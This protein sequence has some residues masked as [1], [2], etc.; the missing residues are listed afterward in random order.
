MN[1]GPVP[2]PGGSRIEEHLNAASAAIGLPVLAALAPWLVG[3][4][5]DSPALPGALLFLAAAVFLY[6]ASTIYHLLPEGSGK[7]MARLFDHAGI[8]LLIAGTYA[9]FCLGPLRPHHG[10]ALFLLQWTLAAAGIGFKILLGFR[11]KRISNLIYLGMGWVG[12]FWLPAFLQEVGISGF[13]WILAGGLFYTA[14]L[15]FYIARRPHAHFVW[16]VFVLAGTACHAW[17]IGRYAP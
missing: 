15:A 13:A 6:L 2:D 12:F 11:W 14:G 10:M 4:F 9:P 7:N 17:A 1:S 3:R 16:H 5:T 8:F